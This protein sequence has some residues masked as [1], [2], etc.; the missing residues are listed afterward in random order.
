MSWVSSQANRKGAGV[1][2]KL[3]AIDDRAKSHGLAVARPT[4]FTCHEVGPIDPT[5]VL[6]DATLS[7]YCLDPIERVGLF[8]RTPPEVDLGL[9]PFLFLTQY[10]SATQLVSVPFD[11]MHVLATAR[12]VP[13]EHLVMVQSTGRCGSTLVSHAFAAA[14]NVMSFSEPDVYYQ[15]H[16]LR[17]Q[18]DTE[19]EHLLKTCTALLCAPW[20]V[21]TWVIKFR[22][23]NIELA[24]PLLRAFSGATTVFLYRRAESW[25]RS[26]ARASGVFSPEALANWDDSGDVLPR[27]RSLVDGNELGHFPSPIESLSWL[28]ST[29]MVRAI[30][31]HNDGVPMFMAR[32]E[33][34]V[35]RPH[36]VLTALFEYCGVNVTTE[37]L[38]ETLALDSQEGTEI[39]RARAAESTSELTEERRLAFLSS[40]AE[41]APGLDPD[42]VI[43][44]TYGA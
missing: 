26:F 14:D 8:V 43:P 16:Q 12:P 40:L 4:D 1:S 31:L 6:E 7:L 41:W 19:F 37:A 11:E 25:A 33:E 22:S 42:V 15:L 3:L 27:V 18:G 13:S 38:D 21:G 44:G 10:Q 36:D 17:D 39:S 9:A 2:A 35:A 34:I 30:A 29:C 28:W 24:G 5:C 20:P 23:L 32:Y